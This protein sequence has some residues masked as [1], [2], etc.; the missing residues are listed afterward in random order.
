MKRWLFVVR[1]RSPRVRSWR[2]TG[3]VLL[4]E[5]GCGPL[6]LEGGRPVGEQGFPTYAPNASGLK[7]GMRWNPAPFLFGC[8]PPRI[9]C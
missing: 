7:V 6:G 9:E 2:V 5:P 8:G 3:D 4:S 1:L